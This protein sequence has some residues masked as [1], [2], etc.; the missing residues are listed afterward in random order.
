MMTS[1]RPL[2]RA[3]V[4]PCRACA[5]RACALLGPVLA[6]A[7]VLWLSACGEP[8]H[9]SKW[10]TSPDEIPEGEGLLTGEDGEWDIYRD[11]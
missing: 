7:S 1:S 4:R 8:L 10:K 3:V 9:P 2:S 5:L 6:A 11:N